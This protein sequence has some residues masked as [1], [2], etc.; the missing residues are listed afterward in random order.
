MSFFTK[1]DFVKKY[2]VFLGY[3]NFGCNVRLNKYTKNGYTAF[4]QKPIKLLT[5]KCTPCFSKKRP[6]KI[7][8]CSIWGH[9]HVVQKTIL[10]RRFVEKHGVPYYRSQT[11]IRQF[12]PIEPMISPPKIFLRIFWCY[13][14]TGNTTG[15]YREYRYFSQMWVNNYKKISIG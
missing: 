2:G 13:S 15:K 7:R 8:G 1:I 10:L 11:Y 9:P 5:L 6:S 12:N 4:G 3:E 14:Q